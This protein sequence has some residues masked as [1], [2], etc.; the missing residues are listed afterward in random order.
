MNDDEL[1]R[2]VTAYTDH[3]E[4]ICAVF[5]DAASTKG[6][7]VR[8]DAAKAIAAID[9]NLGEIAPFWSRVD[10]TGIV[11]EAQLKTAVDCLA[12]LL[13]R[14]E[15]C[16]HVLGAMQSGKTTTSLTL[17]WAGPVLYL[18]TGA[19]HYPFYIISSQTSHEDQTKA[20]LER[21]SAYYGNL[22]FR[23][24]DG[25][26]PASIDVMFA[27][28]STLN[29]YRKYVLRD[30]M[31]YVQPVAPLDDLVHRRVQGH[32]GVEQI[33]SL[34][35]RATEQGYEPLMIIDEPQF[36]ASDRALPPGSDR[37]RQP[38]LLQ[39][40][41]ARIETALGTDWTGHRFVGLS[42]TPFELN[43]LSQVWEVRQY[44]SDGYSGFNRFNGRPI[45]ATA[46]VTPPRTIGLTR[47]AKEVGDP[48]VADISMAAYDG[49]SAVFARHAKRIEFDGDQHEYQDQVVASLH[50]A[51]LQSIEM[52]AL[53]YPTAPSGL[54]VRA[55][56][57][58]ARTEALIGRLGFN[59]DEIE[60]I[61]YFGPRAMGVSIKKMIAR[62]GRPDLPYVIFVT[63]RARMADA[64]PA[65]VRFFLDLSQKAMDLNSL[66]QGLLGRACG[67]G[68]R[69]TVVLSDINARVVEAYD[70][71]DGSYVIRPS[72]HS[73]AVGGGLRRG[74][75]T[76]MIKIRDDLDDDVVREFLHEINVQVVEPNLGIS[77][78]VSPKRAA[79]T[80][81]GVA[82]RT[83]PILRIADKLGL[84]DHIE[85]GDVR[86]ALF[87]QI[88]TSFE[89][90]RAHDSVQ[91]TRRRSVL[92]RYQIDD[93]GDCRFTFRWSAREAAA[94]GGAAGRAKGS[95]DVGQHMEPTIYVEK[96]DPETLEVI[97][98]GDLRPGKWRAFMVTFPLREPVQEFEVATVAYPTETSAFDAWVSD[99]EREL[100]TEEMRGRRRRRT[101]SA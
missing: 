29:T 84:F 58:N 2:H 63:N 50:G 36:G 101:R 83:A 27:R 79:R 17:Q 62:R 12:N 46:N 38:C 51:L 71:T 9:L 82:Y 44:L 57:D 73:I 59:S 45:D 15:R 21:F 92:L 24:V 93:F 75:P 91:H 3:L 52:L 37:S 10:D 11:H 78:R 39:Q 7:R 61:R 16:G 87:P 23:L 25:P 28:S 66:L 68:K 97:P 40:I 42:A 98:K 85:R 6:I 90:A 100:R 55:F 67:Y 13:T 64:F 86:K 34:C 70:N 19:K 53:A 43:D 1:C 47:Y 74:A 96:F 18:L 49:S 33:V 5:N 8:L 81:G 4:R 14:E 88:R 72:R 20:E 54:C 65:E 94:Q 80:T 48:F 95:R 77:T 76:G 99:D 56:N 30:A 31:D 35:K 32:Q 60:V 89:V 22:E 69:S 41:F 26:P